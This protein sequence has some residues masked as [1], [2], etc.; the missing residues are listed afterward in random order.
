M[1]NRNDRV[2]V[3]CWREPIAAWQ[4]CLMQWSVALKFVVHISILF[5]HG[6]MNRVQSL[7]I[8]PVRICSDSLRLRLSPL[9]F[10][11]PPSLFLCASSLAA[12]VDLTLSLLRLHLLFIQHLK[13]RQQP[14]I[15]RVNTTTLPLQ[16]RRCGLAVSE[17]GMWLL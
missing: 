6:T 7:Q 16:L 11:Q 1:H 14:T 5:I 13:H 12:H 10:L 8:R 4:S 2:V 3:A 17:C 9:F 15:V